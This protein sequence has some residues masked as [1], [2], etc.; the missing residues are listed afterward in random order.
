MLLEQPVQ[1]QFAQVCCGLLSAVWK[2]VPI[3]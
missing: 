1:A 2:L 3:D